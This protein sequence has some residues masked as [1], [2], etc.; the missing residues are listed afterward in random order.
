M[1]ENRIAHKDLWKSL[2][3]ITQKNW[4]SAANRLGL[5]FSYRFGKGPHAV[6]RD[7]QYPDPADTR[8]L[9][10]TVQKNLYKQANR[11]IFKKLR[12]WGISEDDIWKALELL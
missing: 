5:S 12:D 2:D 4:E 11:S 1:A 6:I 10:A 3:G 7:P 9:I 8:G